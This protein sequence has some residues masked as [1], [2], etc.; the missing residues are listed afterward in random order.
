MMALKCVPECV[1][2][3]VPPAGIPNAICVNMTV[4][5]TLQKCGVYTFSRR[6]FHARIARAHANIASGKNR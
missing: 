3:C 5:L 4:A 1:C 2:V 6:T